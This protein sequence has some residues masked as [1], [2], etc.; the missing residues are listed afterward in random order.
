[1]VRSAWQCSN[2]ISHAPFNFSVAEAARQRIE[3]L[4]NSIDQ[5]LGTRR[6]IGTPKPPRAVVHVER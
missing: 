2:S 3:Q 6:W 4:P 5:K 1:V